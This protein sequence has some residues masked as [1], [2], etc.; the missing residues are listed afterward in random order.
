[1]AVP[2]DP[3]FRSLGAGSA[4]VRRCKA[5]RGTPVA[6]VQQQQQWESLRLG[7]NLAV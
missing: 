7:I 4:I 5:V 1:M 6:S 3:A 2:G